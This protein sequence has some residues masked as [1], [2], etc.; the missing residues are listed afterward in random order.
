MSDLYLASPKMT[1]AEHAEAKQRAVAAEPKPKVVWDKPTK[2]EFLS[3]GFMLEKFLKNNRRFDIFH[4]S[5]WGSCLRKIAYQWYNEC[6]KFRP[7]SDTDIDFRFER[8][9]DNGH[10]MHARWR[11][12]LDGAGILRGLWKCGELRCGKIYGEEEPLGIFNPLRTNPKWACSACGNNR[13][14]EYE[15]L[16]IESEHEYNF[17]GH[18]DAVIDVRGHPSGSG[19]DDLDLYVLDFKSMKKEYFD[20]LTEPKPEHVIQVHIYMWVLNLKSAVVVYENKNDQAVKEY[21]VPRSDA[22]I[23]DIKKQSKWLI[24]VLRHRR[25]PNRPEGYTRS[26]FPCMF[27][28]FKGICF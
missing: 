22:L 6:E 16:L 14:L 1:Q 5:A 24:D 23:E 10:A 8:V 12:Y 7:K 15:E 26:G 25:L 2:V 20:P 21:F 18:C 9:F 19:N 13:K 3:R 17:E 27:C 28:E 4:P 11:D